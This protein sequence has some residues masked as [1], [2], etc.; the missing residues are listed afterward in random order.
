M[1]KE[2]DTRN[3]FVIGFVAIGLML[4]LDAVIQPGYGMKS[5]LKFIFSYL[6]LCYMMFGSKMIVCAN[7][8]E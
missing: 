2:K 1:T 7:Y 8:F 5:F 4:V 6:S 3:V